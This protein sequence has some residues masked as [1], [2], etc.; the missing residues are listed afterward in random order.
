MKKLFSLVVSSSVALSACAT[1]SKDIASTYT[2]PVQYQSYNCRQISQEMMSI[3]G[4]VTQLGGKLDTA[5]DH[6]KMITG[7][8]VLL[9]WPALFF[10]G[11]NKEQESQYA[12]LK[13]QYEALQQSAIAKNCLK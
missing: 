10:V 5:A 6:D 8:G 4:Q 2:S 11:G 9:F 7:A 3:Q 1:S 12:R 13:G